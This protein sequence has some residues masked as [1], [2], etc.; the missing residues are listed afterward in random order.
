M[1][2]NAQDEL[3]ALRARVAEL[4]AKLARVRPQWSGEL[5]GGPLQ[6]EAFREMW[7]LWLRF[8]REELR[9]PVT[10]I[11]GAMALR[12]LSKMGVDR[13]VAAI[14]HTIANGW[15]GIREPDQP[16][17]INPGDPQP[18][19]DMSRSLRDLGLS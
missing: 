4:E 18:I 10:P 19:R 15:Q 11:S 17:E 6:T 5:P 3:Q 1:I 9:K 7:D 12:A 14:E 16:R 13:A 2:Q 8:R